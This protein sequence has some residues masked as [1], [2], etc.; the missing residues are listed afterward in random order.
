MKR[1]RVASLLVFAGIWLL[2][3]GVGLSE[4]FLTE[5]SDRSG[6]ESLGKLVVNVDLSVDPA[7]RAGL[8]LPE[9]DKLLQKWGRSGYYSARTVASVSG[10]DN[11]TEADVFG[12]GGR[13]DDFITFAM[14]RGSPLTLRSVEE[15]AAAVLISSSLADK[16]YRT[17]DVVGMPLQMMGITFK[18]VGVYEEAPSLLHR[19]TDNGRPDLL[20]PMTTLADLN[21]QL[22]IMTLELAAGPGGS[23]TGEAD[24][25]R[26][27]AAIGKSPSRY[28]IVNLA[29][30]RN[31][32]GQMPKLLLGAAGSLGIVLCAVLAAARIRHMAN[33]LRRGLATEDWADVLRRYRRPIAAGTAACFVLSVCMVAL[34]LTIRHRFYIPPKLIPDVLIDWTFYRDRWIEG[35]QRQV[36]DMG[37]VASASELLYKRVHELVGGFTFAGMLIGL[38]LLGIGLRYWALTGRA[39]DGILTRLAI[40]TCVA[41]ALTAAAASLAGTGYTLR[42]QELLVFVVLPILAA[43]APHRE[44]Q[45]IRERNE[46]T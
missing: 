5:W 46:Y 29:A 35:W 18:I 8:T 45:Q 16:L 37:Y 13:Y 24:A 38:P 42:P 44:H 1:T 33:Q 34:W 4:S 43:L 6:A 41:V 40:Y 19:M 30:E 39:L 22:R 2:V 15:H 26:A 31:W 32:I 20:V 25:S 27:L 11:K 21:P 12:V 7:G 9:A 36:A 3:A 28:K 23:I 14:Y 17:R 10:G